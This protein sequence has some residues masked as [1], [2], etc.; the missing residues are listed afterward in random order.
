MGLIVSCLTGSLPRGAD[1]KCNVLTGV[2]AE[3][4]A[5]D[6][7]DDAQVL[8]VT[9][10]RTDSLSATGAAAKPEP[11]VVLSLGPER[12]MSSRRK[13]EEDAV[14]DPPETF[15]FHVR[16]VKEPVLVSL[17]HFN[18]AGHDDR[19]GDATVY[20]IQFDAAKKATHTLDLVSPITGKCG[21]ATVTLEI[22]LT[23]KT[24]AFAARVDELF[25]YECLNRMSHKWDTKFCIMDPN[26]GMCRW[27][28]ADAENIKYSTQMTD[29]VSPVPPGYRVSADWHVSRADGDAAGWSYTYHMA[30]GVWFDVQEKSSFYRRRRWTRILEKE[31]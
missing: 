16:D 3:L 26:N 28:T 7:P 22:A 11:Y 14:W 2:R 18:L 6:V 27:S 10:L 30:R 12:C 24:Q 15:R 1:G 13:A 21:A 17:Y 25:E 23:D 8:V 5:A 4:L 20:P 31:P 19:V 9:L 29:L